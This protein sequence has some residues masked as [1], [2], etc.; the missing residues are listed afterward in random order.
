VVEVD[1]T[2]TAI[3]IDGREVTLSLSGTI[4]SQ[5]TVRLK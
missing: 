3:E 2:I 4:L 5:L 1:A